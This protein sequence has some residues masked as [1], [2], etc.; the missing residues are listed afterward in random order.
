MDKNYYCINGDTLYQ[1]RARKVLQKLLGILLE[2]SREKDKNGH[3]TIFYSELGEEFNLDPHKDFP[4]PLNVIEY[5]RQQLSLTFGHEVPMI[6]S[7]VVLK[8]GDGAGYPSSGI[9]VFLNLKKNPTTT[10]RKKILDQ[11]MKEVC[12]YPKEKWREVLRELGLKRPKN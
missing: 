7:I 5:T 3:T 10:E 11:K 1:K 9:D 8:T 6:N 12:K 4:D 2:E